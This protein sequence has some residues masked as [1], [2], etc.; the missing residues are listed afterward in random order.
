M[1]VVQGEHLQLS[2]AQLDVVGRMVGPRPEDPGKRASWIDTY[3]RVRHLAAVALPMDPIELTDEEVALA[4]GGNPNVSHIAA[5]RVNSELGATGLRGFDDVDA[6]ATRR[7][8][9]ELALE[10][11]VE[12]IEMLE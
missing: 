4:Q 5:A 2:K 1:S 10:R 3:K 8:A 9:V 12:P 11:A 7:V 6:I